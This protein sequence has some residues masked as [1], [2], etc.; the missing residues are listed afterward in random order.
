MKTKKAYQIVTEESTI[1][2]RNLRTYRAARRV[3]RALKRR[4]GMAC[5]HSAITVNSDAILRGVA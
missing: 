3:I 2:G 4:Y 1:I 5:H